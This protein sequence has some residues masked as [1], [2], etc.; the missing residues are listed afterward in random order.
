MWERKHLIEA[1]CGVVGFGR[2]LQ[3]V[4]G[5][6][7]RG[8]DG[9]NVGGGT[10]G[11]RYPVDSVAPRF[12]PRPPNPRSLLLRRPMPGA[13]NGNGASHVRSP[14]VLACSRP[15]GARVALLRSPILPTASG[16]IP[17]SRPR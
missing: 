16:D 17:P 10:N 13:G 4:A 6:P 11:A 7:A 12:R 8:R 9:D 15:P 3:G 2:A 1:G 5:P 14:V